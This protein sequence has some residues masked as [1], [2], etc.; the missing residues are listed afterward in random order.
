MKIKYL[1]L[2]VF[3]IFSLFLNAQELSD[4]HF[5][6]YKG[7]KIYLPIDYTRISVTLE[8]NF[9]TEDIRA[10]INVSDFSVKNEA[11][12][13]TRLNVV[14]F[15]E[16]PKSG[17]NKKIITAELEFSG[18]MDQTAYLDI[19][20]RLSKANNVIKVAPAYKDLGISNNFYVKLFKPEDVHSLFALAKKYSMEVLG[21]NEFMPLWVTL[22]C[23]RETPF[24]AT[25][26]ANLFYET[27]L[28]ECTEPELLLYHL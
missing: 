2:V 10:A 28:F 26:A 19:I 8:D 23:G 25:E 7:E 27:G 21:Y 3:V 9:F 14:P 1:I 17:R 18:S 20:Q 15:D 12:S 16:S 6:Y 11:I 24:G 13:Y 22:S 4:K 5:Y